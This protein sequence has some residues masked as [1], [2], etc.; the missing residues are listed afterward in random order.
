M[1][2]IYGYPSYPLNQFGFNVFVSDF[3]YSDKSNYDADLIKDFQILIVYKN[4][5]TERANIGINLVLHEVK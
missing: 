5:G 4:N 1:N 2:P 3:L